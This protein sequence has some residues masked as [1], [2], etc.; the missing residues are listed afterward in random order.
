[1]NEV[2]ARAWPAFKFCD[3]WLD[4]PSLARVARLLLDCAPKG[5][6]RALTSTGVT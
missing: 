3:Q 6:E 1:M 2:P 5:V 4:V